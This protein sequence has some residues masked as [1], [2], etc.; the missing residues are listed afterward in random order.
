MLNI[1]MVC[2]MDRVQKEQIL[3]DLKKKIVLLVGPRQAG[4][5]WL[6]KNIANEYNKSV[7][8]N[9]DNVIDKEIIQS[10][11]WLDTTELIILDELHKMPDW[12][13]YLKGIFDTKQNNMHI[14]V[15]GSARLDVYNEIGDSLAGRYFR[16]RLLPFTLSEILQVSNYKQHNVELNIILEQ[17]LLRGGFPE[18]FLANNDLEANRW[19]MQYFSSMLTIDALEFDKIQN[20]KALRTLFELLKKNVGSSISYKSLAEDLL[21][22]PTTV[23]K[24]IQILEALYIIFIVTPFSKNIARSLLKEPKIYFFDTGVLDGNYGAQFEN[25]VAISLLRHT[26]NKVD[27]EAK[28]YKLHYIRTKDGKE[29]DFALVKDDYIEKLIE[30]KLTNNEI[31]KKLKY[32]CELYDLPGAQIVKNLRT[33]HQNGAIEV[34]PA[35]NFLQGL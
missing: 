21:V 16:H 29:V 1:S 10:Q 33:P 11:S 35:V 28:S 18:P 34:I 14:L 17:L 22:S 13:N 6:A 19:R 30:V 5:T 23:K 32:F 26:Y 24:Y 2:D 9:Y 15:T 31:S 20:I 7:Y 3:N 27:Y 8:L 4:K 25:L 12:K